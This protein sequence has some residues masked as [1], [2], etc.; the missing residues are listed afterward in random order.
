MDEL[1]WEAA[2]LAFV[3]DGRYCFMFM[4]FLMSHA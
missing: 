4:R 2:A 1:I 3:K